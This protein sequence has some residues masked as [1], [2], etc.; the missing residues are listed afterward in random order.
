MRVLWLCSWYPSQIDPF[1]GDFIQRHAYAAAIFND[2]YV[3]H[4]AP[5]E[6]GLTTDKVKEEIKN[7]GRLTECVVYF[8]KTTSIFGKASGFLKWRRLFKK[9][10]NDYINKNGRP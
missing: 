2:V 3:I 1:D 6:K 9:A 10:I 8:K 5:D 7:K 4:I